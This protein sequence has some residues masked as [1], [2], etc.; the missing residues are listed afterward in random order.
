MAV[1]SLLPAF[2]VGNVF[3]DVAENVAW[4]MH[5]QLGYDKN[6]YFGAWLTYWF[7]N[8]W[9]TELFSYVLSQFFVFMSLVAMWRLSRRIF[10]SG[11][12]SLVAVLLMLTIPFFSHSACEFNDDVI[13]IGLWAMLILFFHRAIM[14]QSIADWVAVGLV[15]GLSVMTKYLGV[16]LCVSLGTLLFVLPEGRRA[17]RGWGLYIA[18]A[19]FFA[20]VV[21]NLL[22]LSQHDFIAF[23]YAGG[24]SA[25]KM[26]VTPFPRLVNPLR[27]VGNYVLPLLLP[28]AAMAV[29]FRRERTECVARRDMIFLFPAMFG[30]FAVSLLFSLLTGGKIIASWLTPY[31]IVSG[32]FLVAA[33]RPSPDVFRLKIFLL[34]VALFAVTSGVS[35]GYEHLVRRPYQ[36]RS[37]SYDSYPGREAARQLTDEWQRRFNRPL[38]YVVGTRKSSCNMTFYSKDMPHAFFDSDIA[39]SQWIAWDEIEREG[40][41]VVWDTE[42]P[43]IWL[44]QYESRLLILPEFEF[45]R[46]VPAWFRAVA[47]K[48][49]TA[50]VTAAILPPADC[51]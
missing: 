12:H 8:I 17:W 28:V 45:E 10:R 16:A 37:C 4:G 20:L 24:R 49:K 38:K 32:I 14:E 34:F 50:G 25:A 15:A 21:P 35:F 39:L 41:L 23:K 47:G 43:P 3:V 42:K 9:K 40:A 13:E 27:L 44:L 2:C 19:I 7:Y 33:F 1:W 46:A 18:A 6:P 5:F 11:F 29:F 22:W 26:A 30:P 36:R 48:P 31:Y 51:R